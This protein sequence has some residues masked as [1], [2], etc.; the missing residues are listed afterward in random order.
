M[1]QA[2]TF[3]KAINQA[4]HEEF[5]RDPSVFLLGE[6]VAEGGVFLA[7]E[8]LRD[9]FGEQRVIDSPLAEAALIGACT[10]SSLGGMN[11]VAEIQVA[12]FITPAMDQIMQNVAKLRYRSAGQFQPHLTIRVCCG[13]GVGGGLYHSQENVTWF[14]HEPGLV[15][16]YPSTPY[17]AKGLLKSCLRGKDCYLYFEHK[18]LYRSLKEELPA[19]DY[20]VPLGKAAVRREGTDLSVVSFG[21][22]MPVSL[23]AAEQMEKKHGVSCEVIDLRTLLP[24]DKEAILASVKKTSRLAVVHEEK[25]TLGPA[26][27]I[28]ALVQEEAFENLDAP[29]MR[30]TG[31]DIPKMPF[32]PPLEDFYM[33]SA[34]KVVAGLEK[35][36]AY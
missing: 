33:I 34:A 3:I 26:A 35:L 8:G 14:M 32:S 27:E 22:G 30:I 25:R 11:P 19:D 15:V 12:D 13:G 17:D 29:V 2:V 36:A 4:L 18:K 16:V 7:T 31:P 28:A 21:Y 5:E 1:G 23:Q 10:G 9:K 6:D 20:T 24:L